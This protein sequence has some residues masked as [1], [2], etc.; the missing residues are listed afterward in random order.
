MHFKPSDIITEAYVYDEKTGCNISVPLQIKRLKT[1][2][3]YLPVLTYVGGYCSYSVL[4]KIKCIECIEKLTLN[5]KVNLDENYNLIKNL[6]QGGLKCPTQFVVNVVLYNYIFISKLYSE[7]ESSL[8]KH[9]QR[10]I[11]A[12]LTYNLLKS[13]EIILENVCG[14]GHDGDY[15]SKL[16]LH[17]STNIMLKNACTEKNDVLSKRRNKRKLETLTKKWNV[18]FE[19][20]CKFW[21]KN[22][23]WYW[24]LLVFIYT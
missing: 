23:V 6:D 9:N 16:I 11:V 3:P 18:N 5:S 14:N 7:H 1:F 4:K 8:Q 10:N 22:F 24:L 17:V 12:C 15:I 19:I 13:K 20:K 2:E 21:N